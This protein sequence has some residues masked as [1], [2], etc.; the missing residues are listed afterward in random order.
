[1]VKQPADKEFV[2]GNPEWASMS[3]KYMSRMLTN[4]R[5]TG[6]PSG[7]I[8]GRLSG[9][10]E[11]LRCLQGGQAISYEQEKGNILTVLIMVRS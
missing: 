7:I 8:D 11:G 1:M 6:N 4:G 9:V 3:F 2:R 10:S 5:L